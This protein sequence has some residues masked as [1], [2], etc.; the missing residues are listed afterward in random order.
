MLQNKHFKFN[1]RPVITSS[2]SPV[3]V[4]IPFELLLPPPPDKFKRESPVLIAVRDRLVA[5]IVLLLLLAAAF[6]EL[7]RTTRAEIRRFRSS[8]SSDFN[9]ET[10]MSDV[11]LFC[12]DEVAAVISLVHWSG[13]GDIRSEEL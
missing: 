8:R 7:D 5:P 4:I 1:F 10:L 6:L 12:C 11:K 13:F 2:L 9:G 3:D